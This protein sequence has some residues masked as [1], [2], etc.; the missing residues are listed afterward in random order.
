MAEIT[1]KIRNIC[2]EALHAYIT[3]ER[4][5]KAIAEVIDKAHTRSLLLTRVNPETHV[6]ES[7]V[8]EEN[9]ID[10]LVE[11][12]SQHIGAIRGMQEDVGKAVNRA[13]QTRDSMM[14][15]VQGLC[16]LAETMKHVIDHVEN[17]DPSEHPDL[18]AAKKCLEPFCDY[19]SLPQKLT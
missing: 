10:R 5:Q 4:G 18:E 16:A 12:I 3:S 6:Q 13:V 11:E 17:T 1:I 9:V 15:L 14:M 2:V 7:K 8:V 19:I